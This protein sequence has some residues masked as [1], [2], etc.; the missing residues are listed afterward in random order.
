MIKT[1]ENP[2]GRD[3]SNSGLSPLTR[4]YTRSSKHELLKQ[5]RDAVNPNQKLHN[6]IMMVQA[7]M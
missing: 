3:D 2:M 6:I 1:Y 7:G 5:I 4:S